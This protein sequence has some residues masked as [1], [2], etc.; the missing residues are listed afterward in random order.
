MNS[1][2]KRYS[3]ADV[4][5]AG[6]P[7]FW[8]HAGDFNQVQEQAASRESALQQRLNIAD[9]RVCD[10]QIELTKARNLISTL[11][12]RL[13]HKDKGID[14]RDALISEA[15]ELAYKELPATWLSRASTLC[16]RQSAPATKVCSHIWVSADNRGVGAGEICQACSEHR[17]AAKLDASMIDI[18]HTPPME[19]DEP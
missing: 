3:A 6:R 18:V 2:I 13:L 16:V 10:L 19:Y 12:A 11:E 1:T 14:F 5:E 8:V 7:G 4:P 15:S 9:Q 17:P